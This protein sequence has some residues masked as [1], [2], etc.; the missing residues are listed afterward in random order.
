MGR[1]IQIL[2]DGAADEPMTRS[3][4]EEPCVPVPATPESGHDADTLD[5]AGYEVV[6]EEDFTGPALAADRWVARYL[7]QWNLQMIRAKMFD[8]LIGN[9]DPNLGN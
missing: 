2:E 3:T 7:P 4:R 8:D 9:E 5:R 1:P 6:F